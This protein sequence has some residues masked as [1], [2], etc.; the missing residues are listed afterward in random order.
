MFRR[1]MDSSF[2]DFEPAMSLADAFTT[3]KIL[4]L[5]DEEDQAA[6]VSEFLTHHGY[7]V[8]VAHDGP[9]ALELARAFSPDLIL[10]DIG[11][12]GMDGYQVASALCED[13]EIPSCRLVALTGYADPEHLWRSASWSFE[14]HLV[15][16]VDLGHLLRVIRSH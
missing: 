8:A 7:D 16:P 11:L 12:P 15:K 6:L 1:A 14:E 10:V 5:D 4:V 3:Q 13:A 2:S 9:E